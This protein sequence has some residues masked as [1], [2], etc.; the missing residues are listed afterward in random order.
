MSFSAPL[1]YPYK[2]SRL[3]IFFSW[4]LAL[5]NFNTKSKIISPLTNYAESECSCSLMFETVWGKILWPN[6][7]TQRYEKLSSSIMISIMVTKKL[8]PYIFKTCS[9]T[10]L[11][12]FSILNKLF[13]Q[14]L[15]SI[16]IYWLIN[17][18]VEV[19]NVA[20]WMKFKISWPF[21]PNKVCIYYAKLQ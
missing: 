16:E 15:L 20:H 1:R 17:N 6:K 12:I 3:I 11:C 21:R 18:A 19:S 13:F 10:F 9:F 14:S 8:A 7:M 4:A 2:R 5:D